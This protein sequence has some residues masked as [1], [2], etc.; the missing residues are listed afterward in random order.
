MTSH[1]GS[2]SR[3]RRRHRPYISKPPLRRPTRPGLPPRAKVVY[4]H[5]WIRKF[6]Q[7]VREF[8]TYA[9]PEVRPL[10]TSQTVKTTPRSEARFLIESTSMRPSQRQA[11][12]HYL[13][14]YSAAGPPGWVMDP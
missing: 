7:R 3:H 13:A 12:A 6:T 8:Q 2:V 14:W 5:D 4:G 11:T 1:R 9:A 10:I